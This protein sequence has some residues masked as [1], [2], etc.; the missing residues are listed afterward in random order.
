VY[1]VPGQP[2]NRRAA[3]LDDD[4]QKGIFL[5]FARSMKN[6]LYYDLESQSVRSCQHIVFNNGM[7]DLEQPPNARALHIENTPDHLDDIIL[8]GIDDYD[9]FGV[10]FLPSLFESMMEVTFPLDA[11]GN[12]GFKFAGCDLMRQAFVL[13]V[14]SIMHGQG[15]GKEAA[16]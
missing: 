15:K 10:S 2:N 11:T 8:E 16:R 9:A 6:A 4:S 13:K 14:T 12:L 7:T 5:G 3:K 1:A